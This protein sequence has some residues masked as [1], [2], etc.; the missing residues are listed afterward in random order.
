MWPLQSPPFALQEFAHRFLQK[1]L[2]RYLGV[3]RLGL[4]GLEKFLAMDVSGNAISASLL[5][6][7]ARRSAGREM[8]L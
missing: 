7:A 3:A 6:I 2:Q 5:E 1:V 8:F 4:C